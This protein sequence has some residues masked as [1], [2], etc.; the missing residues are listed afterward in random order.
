MKQL[1]WNFFNK[2]VWY[3]LLIVVTFVL[4]RV[5]VWFYPVDSDHWI[6]WYV[7]K[8]WLNG[9]Q[10]YI[11]SWDHKPPLIFLFNGIMNWL[12]GPNLFLHRAFLTL[13]S[14]IDTYLFYRVARIIFARGQDVLKLPG[15]GLKLSLLLYVLLRNMSQFTSSGN[16]TENFGLIFLLLMTLCFFRFIKLRKIVWLMVAGIN[17]GILFW[18]KGNMLILAGPIVAE[19]LVL[20]FRDYRSRSSWIGNILNWLKQTL[21]LSFGLVIFSCLIIGYFAYKNQLPAFWIGAFEYSAKYV[22]A[23]WQGRVSPQWIFLRDLAPFVIPLL[24]FLGIFTTKIRTNWSNPGYRFVFFSNLFSLLFAS[25]L[26]AFYPYYLLILMPSFCLMIGWS[27]SQE[28]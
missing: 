23:T 9:G 17:L 5:P 14:V 27:L 25:L 2:P 22:R 11:D 7:G 12:L 24:I 6:F 15:L 4:S 1:I 19:L 21:A 18:L 16:N 8:T 3:W 26:G 10:L 13:L 20:N 28:F